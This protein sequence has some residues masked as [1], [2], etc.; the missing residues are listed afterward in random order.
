MDEPTS[1]CI[2]SHNICGFSNQR[3]IL[4]SRCDTNPNIFQCVQEH[5]LAPPFKRQAGTNAFRSVH[6]NFEGF[7]VS[8]MKQAEGDK[9]RRGRGFGGTAFIYPKHF[10]GNIKPL[11]KYNHERV[12]VMQL[13][14]T[15]FAIV[16]INV[17]MPFL[18]RADLQNAISSYEEIL[19]YID[20]IIEDIGVCDT[21]IHGQHICT[22][23]IHKCDIE[24]YFLQ[25][26]HF[27][28]YTVHCT[29]Y[30]IS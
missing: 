23:D 12:S 27:T 10:G 11:I 15:N 9:I 3:E 24:R 14:C 2:S 22:D 13:T 20:F 29:F 16:I 19:G 4:L 18:N 21:V 1:I 26:V 25:I 6:T 28:L 7:A 30:K 17:Y 5:W 8:A